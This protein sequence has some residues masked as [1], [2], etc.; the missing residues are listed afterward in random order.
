MHSWAAVMASIPVG[1]LVCRKAVS[2]EGEK[3][4]SLD[5]LALLSIS[6]HS[7][8]SQSWL[9]V[10]AWLDSSPVNKPTS[11]IHPIIA[12][13]SEGCWL[14]SSTSQTFLLQDLLER[15][16]MR[17]GSKP[18]ILLRDWMSQPHEINSDNCH[19]SSLLWLPWN[20]NSRCRKF[21]TKSLCAWQAC[22]HIIP[23]LVPAYW[24][25]LTWFSST[26]FGNVHYL[27]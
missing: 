10:W 11:A 4:I 6:Y 1:P 25:S 13:L 22:M 23:C 8:C 27:T 18:D 26:E 7:L 3:K 9:Q 15:A 20:L 19:I 14:L 5:D 21:Y 12:S 2:A 16:D 24:S 17:L